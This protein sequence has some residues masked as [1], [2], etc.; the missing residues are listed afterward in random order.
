MFNGGSAQPVAAAKGVIGAMLGKRALGTAGFPV[1]GITLKFSQ[2]LLVIAY[3]TGMTG[4]IIEPTELVALQQRLGAEVAH[5][6]PVVGHFTV[7]TIFTEYLPARI[8]LLGNE[9]LH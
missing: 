8:F 4:A 9:Y 5:H 1:Q 6:I 3:G 7:E 2:G